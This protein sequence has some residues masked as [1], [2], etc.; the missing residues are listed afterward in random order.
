[1]TIKDLFKKIFSLDKL[2]GF[3]LIF[4]FIFFICVF[5]Y[6]YVFKPLLYVLLIATFFSTIIFYIINELCFNNTYKLLKYFYIFLFIFIFSVISSTISYILAEKINAD[7][8]IAYTNDEEIATDIKKI[9]KHINIDSHQEKYNIKLNY[10]NKD[11]RDKIII[12]IAEKYQSNDDFFLIGEWIKNNKYAKINWEK[13]LTR[14]ISKINGV[15]K[16]DVVI[17]KMAEENENIDMEININVKKGYDEKE[18]EKIINN[19]IYYKIKRK[20]N[21]N[22]DENFSK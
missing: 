8:T 12:K 14:I 7:F 1:M 9:N 11:Y 15:N 18:I 4:L 21:I 19:L 3:I 22:Y 17:T 16:V 5:C 2:A 20:I 10:G 6:G 13:S